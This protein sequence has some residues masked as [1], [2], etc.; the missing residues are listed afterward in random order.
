MQVEYPPSPVAGELQVGVTYTLWIPPGVPRLRGIIVHQH[1]AGTTASKEG[2]TAAYDLHWQALAKK[3]DCAL[4]GPSY[5]VLNEKIDLSPGASEH[6]FDPRR[7]SAKTF[8]KA[9]GAFAAK[10]AHPE[11][12]TVPWVLWGHSGGGIWS[13]V[14]CTL[15]PDRVAAMWLRSG[16]A[17]MFRTHDEF[18]EPQVPAA[19]YAVPIM[20]NPGVK[21]AATFK[22]N[23]KGKEKGPW[24]GNLATFREY[25]AQ[26]AFIG[27][28]P[29]PRTGHE[30]GDCRYLAILYLDACLAMRLPDKGSKNQPLKPVDTSKAWLAPLLGKETQPAAAFKG[31][32][33]EAVWLPNE[34]VAKAWMEYVQTGAVSDTTPPPAPFN[35]RAWP[36]GAKGEDGTDIVWSAEADFESGIAG[37]IVLRDGQELAKVPHTPV[38]K[39]GRPLFQAMTYHDTPAKPLPEMRY[40]D[41]SAKAGAKYTYEV[42][43]VNSV[44]L[45]SEPSVKASP[46]PRV[47]MSTWY[48]VDQTWPGRPP[49]INW[50]PMSGVAVDAQDNVWVLARTDPPVQVYQ[51]DGKF[52]RAWGTGLLD[53]PHQLKLDPQGNVWLADSGNHVVLQCTPEGKVI[54]TLGTRGEPGC[55]ER[56][57]NRPADMVITPEGDAFVADGYGNAR[58]VHFDKNGNFVKSWGKLGTEAGAFSLPH[59]IALDSR[60]RLYVADRNNARIQVFDQDGKLQG[61]WRNLMVPCAFWMTKDDELWVCGPSPMPWRADDKV[62]G[63]PPNDQL[64]MKFNTSGKLLQLWAV[65]KG[66]DGKER[67]G[68][69]NWV[70]G[71]ALDSNG[72]IYAVDIKGQRAQKFVLQEPPAQ[73]RLSVP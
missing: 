44:G 13:D 9:L 68:E 8:L 2:A 3:W 23:P 33:T 31:N 43:T 61:L 70:H 57:F 22:P 48:Q 53:T 28:A 11:I 49:N 6:W 73:T 39:F 67:P 36:K 47:T 63:Y 35:V 69:L 12:E 42:I 5:H 15:Y 27:F 37:F 30:C 65:P 58:V 54:R 46:Y 7:G 55:D 72:N 56:H 17:A 34:A 18:P 10:A 25:R 14:M 1:G 20:L 45:K 71:L 66:E 4:L 40:L 62:L 38:G 60:G 19:A 51:P 16:S 64:F 50:G 24:F 32:P 41:A 21:E 26:G 59:A 29:D 52:L